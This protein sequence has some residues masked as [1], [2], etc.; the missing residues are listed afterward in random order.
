MAELAVAQ[1]QNEQAARL[2]GSAEVLRDAIALPLQ[3]PDR[4][5]HDRIVA[6][7]RA[8]L[9]KSTFAAAWAEGRSMTL[10]QAIA[11][12]LE[13]SEVDPVTSIAAPP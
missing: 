6:A 1:G 9:D 10:E 2:L 8:Q 12:A 4:A 13:G 7:A 5:E 11:Y 3:P